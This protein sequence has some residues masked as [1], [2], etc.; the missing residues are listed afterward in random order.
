MVK[1]KLQQTELGVIPIDWQILTFDDV[2]TGFSAGMTPYRGNPEYYK[3]LIPWVTSGEL[4]YNLITDTTEKITAN[5]VVNTNLK[6]R[7][8]GTFLMAITG[9]EAAGTRGS[10]ALLGIEATTNQ[11]CLALFSTERCS[12]KYLYYF[13]LKYGEDYAFKFAQGTKQQ[14]FTGKI[15]KKF[16]IIVPPTIEEQNAIVEA[17]TDTDQLIQNLKI[18][19][20]KKKAIKQGAMQELLT[21]KKRLKGFDGKW[22]VKNLGV[23][24]ECLD[25]LRIP[26]NSSER[27]K[28]KG[29]IPYCGANGVVDY[30]NDY[31][32]DDDIILIAEDGGYFDEYKTRPIAYQIK[33][34]CWVNNHAHIIRAKSNFD[35]N[36]LFYSLVNKNILDFIVGGTRAKLNKSQLLKIEI[37]AS[38]AI[39]EQKAIAQILSDMDYEIEALETQL[40]KTQNL[41]Q[42]M[43]QELLTGKIR[44]VKPINQTIYK[45]NG[46][47]S[48][49]AEPNMDY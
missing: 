1:A 12:T 21:G 13:Y 40:Q 36:Y 41:K 33:G 3:G 19:I 45:E 42:G 31:V 2:L 38:N 39:E 44:L 28:M 11:S 6:L 49:A 20:A 43:M 34:K 4:N 9:L 17:L 46:N 47:I 25:N 22:E 48:I 27:N 18:L 37:S 14:S 23:V 7:P 24:S 5:A 35:N 10:C 30:V 29:N 8:K 26:L 32:I 15:V 16:P